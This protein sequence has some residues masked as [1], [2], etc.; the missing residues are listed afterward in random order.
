MLL[1]TLVAIC[2]TSA[3]VNE[4]DTYAQEYGLPLEIRLIVRKLQYGGNVEVLL[5]KL[6]NLPQELQ[7]HK[8]T[9][10]YLKRV[11]ED[12]K[13]SDEELFILVN[14]RLDH[15][16]D[17]L[18][19][20]MEKRLNT[21]PL[22]PDTEVKYALD[23]LKSISNE[24]L[25]EYLK[26]GIDSDVVE[27]IVLLESLPKDFA[28]Y[29]L[30]SKLCIEDR[31]LTQLERN[32][33]REPDSYSQELFSNY[34]CEIR[35]ISPEL[36]EEL[37][38]LPDFKLV[39]TKD[40]EGLEDIVILAGN[41]KYGKVFDWIFNEGIRDKRKYCSPLEALL[42]IAYDEEFYG[43]NPTP[44]FGYNMV[45]FAWRRSSTSRYYK[46]QKWQDYG[47]VI[48]RLN[49]PSLVSIYME[50]NIAYDSDELIRIQQ[51]HGA[52][53]ANPTETF[54]RRKGVCN[55]QARFALRCLL[56]NGYKYNDFEHHKDRAACVIS[57]QSRD[58]PI[59]HDT[60]LYVENGA[61]YIIDNG[62]IRGSYDSVEEAVEATK[63]N[64]YQYRFMDVGGAIIKT[65]TK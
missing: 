44:Y 12:R 24:T 48:Y 51:G 14:D 52:R 9:L 60:C 15:D 16:G 38:I 57:A 59:G 22:K 27:Y 41:P 53:V 3:C 5:W 20:A 47:E 32:F 11:A 49:S 29:A 62:L 2:L 56:A 64:W 7:T 40:V 23:F 33:L 46:S 37:K 35:E 34:L 1:I 8:E 28:K 21:D 43:D 19:L 18:D 30:E 13:V 61:F 26:F 54:K 6:Q 50:D 58:D 65:V 55:E 31:Q 39:E 17:G 45:K 36:E 25:R 10:S 4:V 63:A 42:W